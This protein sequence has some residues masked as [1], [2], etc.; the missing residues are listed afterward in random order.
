LPGQTDPDGT[1]VAFVS[2]LHF[3][4]EEIGDTLLHSQAYKGIPLF[5]GDA[6][7]IPVPNP[8][9]GCIAPPSLRCVR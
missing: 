3:N 5:G 8:G 4:I 2:T 9:A 7:L 6:D 1:K